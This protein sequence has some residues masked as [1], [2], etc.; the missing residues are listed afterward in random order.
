MTALA[1]VLRDRF[2]I[3]HVTLQPEPPHGPD[4]RRDICSIDAPEGRAACLTA[5]RPTARAVHAGH[6]H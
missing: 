5:T 3:A 1:Q 6:R 4:A 2:A